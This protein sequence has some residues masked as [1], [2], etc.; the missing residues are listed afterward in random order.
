MNVLMDSGTG[1]EWKNNQLNDREEEFT[2][3][4]YYRSEPLWAN[5]RY[6]VTI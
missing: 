4:I 6:M 5:D 2:P 3:H 1:Q